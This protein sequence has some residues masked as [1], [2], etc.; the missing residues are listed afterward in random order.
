MCGNSDYGARAGS[1]SDGVP[2]A[3]ASGSLRSWAWRRRGS[4]ITAWIGVGGR[5]HGASGLARRFE[6]EEGR[7]HGRKWTR[8][9]LIHVRRMH[10][11]TD[12]VQG[13]RPVVQRR[14]FAVRAFRRRMP[15]PAPLAEVR[16]GRHRHGRQGPKQRRA[17]PP[18][19]TDTGHRDLL[20]QGQRRIC[21]H[22]GFR[23]GG[24]TALHG[25]TL[26]PSS[27]PFAKSRLNCRLFP[28][29]AIKCKE[30]TGSRPV[31]SCCSERLFSRG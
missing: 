19:S 8:R 11:G 2:V 23:A 25:P 22:I 27:K 20:R 14:V 6:R 30:P 5:S 15:A 12:L 21:F 28:T 26:A 29:R 18:A 31:G 13:G 3:Y 9:I 10:A 7:L 4:I 1:V 16:T 17:E 24:A